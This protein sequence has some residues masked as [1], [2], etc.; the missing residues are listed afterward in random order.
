MKI[1]FPAR[2]EIMHF[3]GNLPA[4]SWIV[5]LNNPGVYSLG[6]S[7]DNDIVLNAEGV[8][9]EHLNFRVTE[10]GVIV[11][12]AEGAPPII[13]DGNPMERANLRVGEKLGLPGH[14]ISLLTFERGDVPERPEIHLQDL[15]YIIDTPAQKVPGSDS[16]FPSKVFGEN[17]VVSI[18]KLH[19]SGH[20]VDECRFLA[21]G[22][23]FGSFV[24]VDHL[25]VYGAKVSDIRVIGIDPICYGN[26]KR[27]CANSQ[28]PDHE[29]LRSNSQSTP[30]NI[31]GF[32]GYAS[33]ESWAG[34][35]RGKISDLKYMFQ[36]LGEPSLAESY[37]PRAG[38]VFNSM[39]REMERIGWTKMF[40]GARAL[41]MRKTDDGRFVVALRRVEPA[42]DRA[43]REE[44]I[45]AQHVHLATGY[46][47]TRF[48]DD[49]RQFV[50]QYPDDR[51]LVA[52][53]YEEHDRMYRAC[54]QTQDE[55]FVVVRGRGIVASRIIQR[56]TEARKI[57]PNLKII[58]SI[59]SRLY[60]RT[61][62]R[63]KWASRSAR[64]NVELQPFNW[65]K[66]CWS[67]DLRQEHE[68]GGIELRSTMQRILG[69]TTTADRTDWQDILERGAEEGWYR[70]V[71]G[72]I[73]DLQPRGSSDARGVTIT[74]RTEEGHQE[75]LFANY[76]IDC[77][78]L[79]G[80][81]T[82]SSFLGNLLDT[83]RL[84]RNTVLAPGRDGDTLPTSAGLFVSD[85]FE[86]EALRS[87]RGSV[88]AS[89]T[90]TS[91]GPYLAVDSFLGLQYA[92]FRSAEAI[93]QR[94]K[95]D[96]RPMTTLRSFTQWTKWCANAAP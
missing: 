64:S 42:T 53:A 1:Q 88:W 77:T 38:H 57:N 92:A 76:L 26:Y 69:G 84:P 29:R 70:P 21:V 72:S 30:D 56:L 55:C 46:P 11:E 7:T 12:I 58:H 79:I 82:R 2:L 45:V 8:L 22:G 6:L 67:G 74:I 63:W 49:F 81:V 13:L 85:S 91:G 16:V 41:G 95:D 27:Y 71:F 96:L 36:V 52:N 40:Q 20:K 28:I 75:T 24:W 90:I 59:R 18:S 51:H 87:D 17:P 34:V 44:F 5:A 61:G 47:T 14:E 15:S 62:A 9:S 66:A 54:E 4:R 80:D 25:R 94:S 65:P 60:G 10:G 43:A 35:K 48:V 23:G 3:N 33:R 32:P 86:V 19:A 89:G 73:S 37:T 31:W 83:Y 78:G 39:D 68:D 93:S 50:A